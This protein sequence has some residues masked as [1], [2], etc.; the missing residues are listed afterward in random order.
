MD[1][2]PPA[3]GS[4]SGDAVG[5]NG[6]ET[7]GYA[8]IGPMGHHYIFG[9]LAVADYI[10]RGERRIVTLE[11]EMNLPKDDPNFLYY[12]ELRGGNRWAIATKAGPDRRYAIYFQTAAAAADG[13]PR[14]Q[15]MQR[16]QLQWS[17]RTSSM[18]ESVAFE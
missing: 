3:V 2:G 18:A 12:R 13:Q 8:L 14:W 1:D 16:A 6:I 7:R 11:Q 5:M 10:D 15:R 4:R 17:R 9:N